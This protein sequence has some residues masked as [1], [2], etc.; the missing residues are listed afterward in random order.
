MEAVSSSGQ[1]NQV[2]LESRTV[3]LEPGTTKNREG[4]LIVLDGELLQ[5]IEAQWNKRK[6]AEIPGRHRAYLL[7]RFSSQRSAN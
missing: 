2:D 3:R 7:I 1:W 5:V 6:I 4:R